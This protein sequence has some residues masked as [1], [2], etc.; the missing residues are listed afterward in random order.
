MKFLTPHCL[1]IF[2]LLKEMFLLLDKLIRSMKKII[3]SLLSVGALASCNEAKMDQAAIDA[4]VNE[5]AA[6]K[7]KEAEAAATKACDERMAS[8]E[9]NQAVTKMVQEAQA[10]KAQTSN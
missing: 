5:A 7:I 10:A 1:F 2:C 8:D 6:A 3:F 9:F 4:K